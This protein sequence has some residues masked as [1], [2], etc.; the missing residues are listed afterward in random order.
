MDF[1]QKEGLICFQLLNVIDSTKPLRRLLDGKSD[2]EGDVQ[3]S[4]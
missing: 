4:A 3:A 2:L 1:E